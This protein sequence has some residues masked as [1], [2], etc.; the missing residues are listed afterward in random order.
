MS[1][2]KHHRPN[3]TAAATPSH[4]RRPAARPR[5]YTPLA[6]ALQ[7]P[8]AFADTELAQGMSRHGLTGL[9]TQALSRKR[10]RDG[11][12]LANVLCALLVWPLL[13][14][15]SIHCFCAQLGQILQGQAGVLYDFLGREDICW[16]GLSSQVARRVLQENELGSPKQRAFV[17]DDSVQARAGRKVEGTS[18]HYDH[19]EGKTVKGHQV[20]QLGLA[21]ETGFVPLEA[22]I[23]MSQSQP[24]DKPAHKPFKDQRSSAARDLSRARDQS[25][26]ELFRG[27]LRRALQAGVFAAYLLADAWFGCKENLALALELGLI[28]IF[29][30]KRGNLAYR[31]QGRDYTAAQLY[32]KV[33]RRM[34]PAHRKARYK[35]A[36]LTVELNLQTERDQPAQWVKV[37]LVFSAPVRATDADTWVVFVCTDPSLSDQRILEV[38]ALRWSIEVYFKEIKQNLGFLKEQSGRYQVAYASVHLAALRYLL[39]FEGML[40]SGRLTYGEFRDRQSG[41]IQVLTYATLLWQLFRALIEGALEGLVRDLGRKVVRYI[42]EAI[43]QSVEEF[44]TQALQMK[45]DQ[46]AVQLEAEQLGYL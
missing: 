20:L 18:C 2:R 1:R 38:Y 39:L 7:D 35:T 8:C 43:D 9:L 16:R 31:Y 37:R 46:V 33:Q 24:V 12:P 42:T 41:Q 45:P 30:M 5:S 25:K 40:R 23:V 34:R 22:Q 27:M 19:T 26:P 6:D 14:L 44:L 28:G 36:G 13:T 17:V 15:K 10:R 32:T 11:E 4:G 29:Q 3:R 21:A